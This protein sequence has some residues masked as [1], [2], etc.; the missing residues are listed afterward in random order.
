VPGPAPDFHRLEHFVEFK[1][2]IGKRR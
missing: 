1:L 2:D